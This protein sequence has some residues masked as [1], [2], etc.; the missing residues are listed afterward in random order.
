MSI[1]STSMLTADLRKELETNFT[2]E[3][4]K[5]CSS[6]DEAKPYLKDA[7]ILITLGEDLTAQD[8][9]EAKTLKWIMIISAGM[10]LM[11]FE[12][13]HDK[14]ILV[15]NAKGIHKKPMAEYTMSMILQY[16]RKSDVLKEQERMKHWNRKVEMTEIN[17]QSIG[18][19]GA[20]AIG[21]EIA[22]LSKAFG[23][24]T[25]GL[26][27]NGLQVDYIDKTVTKNN[28][29]FLLKKVDYVV[30]VLPATRETHHFISQKAFKTMKKDAVFINIGRGQ[31]LNEEALINAL[32]NGEI[33]HA[34]LDV[35]D[36]EPL[37]EDHPFW[38]MDNVTVTPHISGISSYYLPR[39]MDIF[40]Q[41]LKI[42]RKGDNRFINQIDVK[43]GY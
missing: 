18:V 41:N 25:I 40:K 30:S 34:I 29:D 15:T 20:G 35:F 11:P 16:A 43:R 27:K 10:D 26:N 24:Q 3:S 39:A 2:K 5:F 33:A 14:G 22:R 21:Q 13:I 38:E 42:Y 9:E 19:L 28:L 6:I 8:I 7:E 1:L 36:Q 17:Q 37:P 31:T 12:A 32:H 4:F 23:L